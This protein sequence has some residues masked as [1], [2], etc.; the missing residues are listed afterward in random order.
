MSKNPSGSI[1]LLL[2]L[3]LGVSALSAAPQSKQTTVQ[4]PVAGPAA[5]QKELMARCSAAPAPSLVP[6]AVRA[7]Y[8]QVA[9][10]P[11]AGATEFR[12]TRTDLTLNQSAILTPTGYQG[13]FTSALHNLYAFWDSVPNPNDTYRYTLTALQANGCS[14]SVSMTAGPFTTPNPDH[15]QSVRTG[16]STAQLVWHNL[17]GA[18]Y[19][20]I[21]GPGMPSTGLMLPAGA[22]TPGSEPAEAPSDPRYTRVADRSGA[23]DWP[24]DVVMPLSNL[25]LGAYD[26]AVTA[27]YPGNFA[28]YTHRTMLHVDAVPPCSVTA[29]SPTSGATGT[30]I[31]ITGSNLSFTSAV[32]IVFTPDPSHPFALPYRILS[33]NTVTIDTPVSPP[34]NVLPPAQ[35]SLGLPVP[36][37]NLTPVSGQFR[38]SGPAGSCTSPVY[39]WGPPF[40]PGAK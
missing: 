39:S 15:G 26:Y 37:P 3:S 9:W 11:L 7:T 36:I 2:T 35:V 31:T 14:G 29:I 32:A 5:A 30:T 13:V 16:A 1:V 25:G 4:A 24:D 20:R 12:I 10:Q 40:S 23:V 19:Y 18:I 17:F 28:D 38:V 6:T 33:P 8:A 34:A 21:D 22:Y 27:L